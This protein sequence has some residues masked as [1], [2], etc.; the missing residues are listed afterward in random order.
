MTLNQAITILREAGIDSPIQDAKAIFRHF[1]KISDAELLFREINCDSRELCQ[2]ISRR[3]AREPLQYIIGS[4]DFYREHYIV[5]PACLIPRSDT[6]I[7][8]DFAVSNLPSGAT[9]MDLC[10]GSGC[11]AISVLCNT[12]DTRAIA[13]DIDA[14]ALK[15]AAKNASLNKV[16]NRIDLRR[17]DLM[18]SSPNESVFAV[19][20]NPPYVTNDAYSGLESEIFHEPRHA[21]VGGSDGGDFYRHLTPIY[22]DRIADEGFIAYEIGYDQAELLREIAENNAMRC[23]IIK[24]LG[25]ND[26]VAVLRKK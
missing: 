26:R 23:Q 12:K 18:S 7:L 3:A 14:E 17:M 5:S 4:V 1:G 19:L 15:I 21:F 8:V 16:E 11:V 2:A 25:G 24:D 13:I 20:S 22:K 10:T 9:F 6:E